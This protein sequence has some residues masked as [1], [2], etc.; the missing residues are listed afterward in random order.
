VFAFAVPAGARVTK[1]PLQAPVG[2]P[3]EQTGASSTRILGTGWTSVLE[4]KGAA[5][6]LPAEVA[7]LSTPVAGSADRLVPTALVNAVLRPDGTVFV[8]AVRPAALEHI[9]ATAR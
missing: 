9:A 1:T 4:L 3:R 8:G 7:Q 2:G 6:D 5:A